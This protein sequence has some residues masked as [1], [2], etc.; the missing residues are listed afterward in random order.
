MSDEIQRYGSTSPIAKHREL[1]V[2]GTNYIV[3]YRVRAREVEVAAALHTAR[4]W[5]RD[6]D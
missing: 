3:P 2:P 1:V 6:F 5:P 4:Q